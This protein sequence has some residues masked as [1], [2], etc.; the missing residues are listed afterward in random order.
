MALQACAPDVTRLQ[1]A[2]QVASSLSAMHVCRVPSH[3]RPNLQVVQVMHL[4]ERLAQL[5]QQRRALVTG[6]PQPPI[7]AALLLTQQ[8]LDLLE[9]ALAA[10]QTKTA[11]TQR[12]QRDGEAF[13]GEQLGVPF[14]QT[15]C[16]NCSARHRTLPGSLRQ[17]QGCTLQGVSLQRWRRI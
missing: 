3:L 14:T 8:R 6:A 4:A 12:Q 16:A 15:A 9:A 1:A 5:G 10:A 13:R 7:E 17:K 11:D 2:Q